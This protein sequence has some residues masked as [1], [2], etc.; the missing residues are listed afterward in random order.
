MK[1]GHRIK[2]MTIVNDILRPVLGQEP[3]LDCS[4]SEAET[5]LPYN[6]PVAESCSVNDEHEIVMVTFYAG[7]ASGIMLYILHY[8]FR[9]CQA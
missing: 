4:T 3:P 2:V 5:S 1:T 6:V 9:R 7:K 8:P